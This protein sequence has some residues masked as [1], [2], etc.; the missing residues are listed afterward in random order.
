MDKK[1]VKKIIDSDPET[2]VQIITSLD[3]VTAYDLIFEH[4]DP[5]AVAK[6]IPFEDA[7]LLVKGVGE[8]DALDF[9]EMLD[10]EKI[11]GFLDLDCWDKDRLSASKAHEWLT[12]L[13]EFSDGRFLKQMKEMDNYL[14][15]AIF[16]PFAETIKI[17]EPDENP[18][19]EVEDIFVTP[20]NRYAIRF[21]GTEDQKKLAYEAIIRIYRLDL[22]HFYWLLEG[23]YWE[24]FIE[25]EEYAYQ[26]KTARLSARGF[27][28]YYSALEIFATVDPEKFSPPDKYTDDGKVPGDKRE[29]SM[30]LEKQKH[31][32][33]LLRR[34]LLHLGVN[35]G[36]VQIELITLV[37]MVSLANQL[38][39]SDIFEIGQTALRVDGYL[40]LAIE[41]L[42]GDNLDTGAKLLSDKRLLDLYKIGRSLVLKETRKLRTHVRKAAIDPTTTKHLL[43]GSPYHEFVDGMLR[44]D[45]TIVDEDGSERF[46][47]DLQVLS[48]ARKRIDAIIQIIRIMVDHFGF[49]AQSVRSTRILGTNQPSR[50]DVLYTQLFCTSFVNDM[51]GRDFL[52]E[53]LSREECLKIASQLEP[54][55]EDMAIARADKDKMYK[56]LAEKESRLHSLTKDYFESL[57][58]KM[59]IELSVF[60]KSIERDVRFISSLIIKLP[61]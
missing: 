22:K 52:P 35:A 53:P 54:K 51:L 9:L 45:P 29:N 6:A 43:L 10:V 56:W 13:M 28:D 59:A 23:I 20:D 1:I 37:N 58:E 8:T 15:V 55:G 21:S 7:Y 32:D 57:F 48:E 12:I 47:S 31:G 11:Q 19:Y 30:F 39:F 33:S 44:I 26:D 18:F 60:E 5:P 46:V 61:M 40:S 34:C 42:S 49:T 36:P 24:T 27:P 17:E 2:A 14:K 50:V 16:K 25:L 4:P 38:S 41:Y 3:P